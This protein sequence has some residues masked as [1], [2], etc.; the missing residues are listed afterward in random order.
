MR[1]GISQNESSFFG[2]LSE[3]AISDPNVPSEPFQTLRKV[4]GLTTYHL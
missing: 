4:T 2:F 1:P 3:E